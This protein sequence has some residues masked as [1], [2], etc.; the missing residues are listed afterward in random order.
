MAKTGAMFDQMKR[1]TREQQR[2]RAENSVKLQDMGYHVHISAEKGRPRLNLK[3]VWQYR[4]LILLLTKKTFTL[5][6]KQTVLGPAW[7]VISP[8]LS[9][10]AYM[11]VFGF[12]AG[13]STDGV[14]QVL[15]Y[16]AGTAIWG[17][18][19]YTLTTN[20]G[21]FLANANVFAKVY[22]PRLTVPVS[23]LLVGLI[24]FAI[25]MILV[26]V[27]IAFF[28]AQGQ[29]QPNWLLW[30][31]IPVA[32]LHLCLLG[33]GLGIILSS[34]TTKYRDLQILVSF[35]MQLWMFATPIVYPLTQI[36]EGVFRTAMLYN[37]VTPPVEWL[38]YVLFGAGT[39]DPVAIIVSA[40][41]TVVCA[42]AGILLFNHVE[43]TFVDTV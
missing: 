40:L 16:L 15:F 34:L 5:T 38:R 28:V 10:L 13:I 1:I 18:F 8:L 26:L 42:I 32:L 31:T 21:T 4:D 33:M 43:R 29:I 20:A 12:I 23:T 3:E 7:I 24:R 19:A 17:L 35:G 41:V 9:S 6:Y 36:P 37:P 25:Q 39:V 27:L 11:V 22:F 2:Q 30:L 14:P